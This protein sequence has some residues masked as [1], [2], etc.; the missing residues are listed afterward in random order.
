M[1]CSGPLNNDAITQN[2]ATAIRKEAIQSDYRDFILSFE[3][4]YYTAVHK[5]YDCDWQG[6][7]DGWVGSHP[8]LL[9]RTRNGLKEEI[10]A[11]HGEAGI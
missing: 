10:D 6:E 1:N 9:S 4:G 2:R 3:Y 7:E 11:W 5:E 8:I